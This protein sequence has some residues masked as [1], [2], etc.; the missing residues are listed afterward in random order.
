M[1]EAAFTL[2]ALK[3]NKVYDDM[4]FITENLTKLKSV[5]HL[6]DGVHVSIGQKN[7]FAIP[8]FGDRTFKNQ[9][10]GNC[11]SFNI[12]EVRFLLRSIVKV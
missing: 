3:K 9:Q 4:V 7:F 12:G 1:N 10:V 5:N 11:K 6:Y 2:S 8:G